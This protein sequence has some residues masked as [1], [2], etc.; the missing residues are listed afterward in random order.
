[1][2]FELLICLRYF[3]AKTNFAGFHKLLLLKKTSI[4][5]FIIV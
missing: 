2:I 1:M 4:E 5:I 3:G